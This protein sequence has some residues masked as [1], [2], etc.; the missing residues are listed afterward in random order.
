[1]AGKLSSTCLSLAII[2]AARPRF[3]LQPRDELATQRKGHR[4]AKSVRFFTVP[5]SIPKDRADGSQRGH[6]S[7]NC[8]SSKHSKLPV[9]T[10]AALQLDRKTSEP[11]HTDTA[12]GGLKADLGT[13]NGSVVR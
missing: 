2:L 12:L 7:G 9:A 6:N 5:G 8:D 10:L 1:M 13:G 11:T 4:A 3:F